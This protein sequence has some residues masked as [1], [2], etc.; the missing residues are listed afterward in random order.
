MGGG[1]G[2]GRG[3]SPP[4]DGVLSPHPSTPP[5]PS[6][7]TQKAMERQNKVQNDKF[8]SHLVNVLVS[9]VL[10]G[11]GLGLL[12]EEL[13]DVYYCQSRYGVALTEGIVAIAGGRRCAW[14]G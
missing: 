8:L 10:S 3:G 1:E 6:P 14:G 2:G 12:G 5:P 9:P 11:Q 4:R 7:P 13:F